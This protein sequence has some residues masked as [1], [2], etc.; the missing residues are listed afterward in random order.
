MDRSTVVG[1]PL[2]L[3]LIDPTSSTSIAVPGTTGATGWAWRPS[4][5]ST[6]PG[7][8]EPSAEPLGQTWTEATVPVVVDRPI[9]LIEAVSGPGVLGPSFVAV[10]RGCMGEEPICEAIVWT[11]VD[12][13]TWVRPPASDATNI[14][15]Y[16][17]TTGP[18]IGMFDVTAGLFGGG[19]VAIGYAARP[20][21]Q[22][23]TWFSPD[24]TTWER[25]PLGLEPPA[26]SPGGFNG[27][28]V[29]AVT[30]DGRQFVIVGED[31]SDWKG[32]GSTLATAKARAAVWTS[33]DGRA[34]TRVPHA[35]VFEVGGF[36]D[37]TEDPESGRMSDVVAGPEGL[38]AVGSVCTSKPV[39]CEPAAWTSSD[40]TSWERVAE[41]PA[42]S[43]RLE[44]IAASDT[45]YVAVGN[46][47]CDASHTS[48]PPSCAGLVLTSTDGRTWAKRPF[49][50]PAYLGTVTAIGDR[51]FATATSGP[52]TV[53]VSADGKTW[54]PL[55]AEGG[56]ST[57][58]QGAGVE[59]KFGADNV[60]AVWLGV[61]GAGDPAA[62][63]S[64]P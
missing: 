44:A 59:L 41:M 42:L 45:G 34:W 6:Q 3:Q 13:H 43:G 48:S 60:T 28:R 61:S 31:R 53:W 33:A 36:I 20:D 26:P 49:E 54:A 56:P 8:P 1:D 38:V 29:N 25:I 21:L 5:A 47:G 2:G 11:S 12:G 18:E 10:G 23:T 9:G 40:G 50:G 51:F 46:V 37:T 62:W 24:G 22:A 7:E 4:S 32:F 63:V 27:A 55:E 39:G 30:W 35:P 17:S 16:L 15:A 57:D 58:A 52:E 64:S 14:G 19:F